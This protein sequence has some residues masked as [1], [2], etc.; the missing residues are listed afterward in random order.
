MRRQRGTGPRYGAGQGGSNAVPAVPLP[1]HSLD[2][3]ASA[4]VSQPNY[5]VDNATFSPTYYNP[6]LYCPNFNQHSALFQQ[7]SSPSGG[8]IGLAN[9]A[10]NAYT[11][12]PQQMNGRN[13]PSPSPRGVTLQQHQQDSLQRSGGPPMKIAYKNYQATEEDM[14][15]LENYVYKYTPP[16]EGHASKVSP[17]SKGARSNASPGSTTANRSPAKKADASPIVVDS[18]LLFKQLEMLKNA[19]PVVE[20][21]PLTAPPVPY[22]NSSPPQK[23]STDVSPAKKHRGFGASAQRFNADDS[24]DVGGAFFFSCHN[25]PRIN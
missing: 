16:A 6:Q 5:S 4:P 25:F 20:G 23:Q 22:L 7:F 15:M 24:I 9:G 12:S 10:F 14:A 19:P 1:I 21:P 13:S 18:A 17:Q 11:A 2:T 3:T 8:P